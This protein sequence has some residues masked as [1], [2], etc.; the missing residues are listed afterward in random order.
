MM[1][2]VSGDPHCPRTMQRSSG[3]STRRSA[4]CPRR[5]RAAR[6]SVTC[7]TP[8]ANEGLCAGQRRQTRACFLSGFS[9]PGASKSAHCRRR[10]SAASGCEPRR[11]RCRTRARRSGSGAGRTR[12]GQRRAPR[13]CPCGPLLLLRPPCISSAVAKARI[14]RPIPS[15]ESSSAARAADAESHDRIC[16]D[17]YQSTWPSSSN[18]SCT[19]RPLTLTILPAR[20]GARGGTDATSAGLAAHLRAQAFRFRFRSRFRSRSRSRFRFSVLPE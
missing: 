12:G 2:V 16:H 7:Q 18:R 13:P 5:R 14:P 19:W 11:P 6:P 17:G 9:W 20:F 15:S 10:A 4:Y 3:A 8:T 1:P